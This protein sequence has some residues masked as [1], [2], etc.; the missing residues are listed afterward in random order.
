MPARYSRISTST[1]STDS[2]TTY[3]VPSMRKATVSGCASTRSMRSGLSANRSP[4]RRVTLI[5]GR[6]SCSMGAPERAWNSTVFI[7]ASEPALEPN[8]PD[9]PRGVAVLARRYAGRSLLLHLDE[10]LQDL[11]GRGDHLAVGLET[12]L[13]DDQAGE[14]LGE[15]DVRHLERSGRER[16]PASRA[17]RADLR[18]PGIDARGVG[19]VPRLGQPARVGEVRDRQLSD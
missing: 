8:R 16:A 4:F 11:V 7:G 13:G 9:I 1:S 17:G 12:A 18:G 15:V 10:V 14:L 5:T 19:A 3:L 2:L 6:S